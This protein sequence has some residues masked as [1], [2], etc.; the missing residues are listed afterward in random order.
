MPEP[1]IARRCPSC[2]ASIRDAASF[3]PQCGQKL[4]A[5]N[6]ENDKPN[7]SA[8][9]APLVDVPEAEQSARVD[10]PA[11]PPQPAEKPAESNPKRDNASEPQKTP[12]GQAPVGKVRGGIQ[13]ATTL[14][15]GVEGDVIHR[16]QK[17]REISSV[18]LDEAGYDP[19]LRFLLVACALFVVFL[20]I[21]LLNKFIT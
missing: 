13:R 18:V 4:V 14:A 1:E 12:T 11:P 6:P 7:Y 9:T 20:I 17:V 19:S 3:C 5:E 21:V 8:A 15:R 10:V 2:G 16:V